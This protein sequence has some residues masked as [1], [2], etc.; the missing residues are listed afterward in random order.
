VRLGVS[1]HHEDMP[2]EPGKRV[3][4]LDRRE[5]ASLPVQWTELE[6]G[7]QLRLL[8]WERGID[9]NHLYWVT[10]HPPHKCWLFVQAGPEPATA[11]PSPSVKGEDVFYR[12]L[13]AE[14]RRSARLACVTH[15][16]Y[17]V[18][19]ELPGPSVDVTPTDL[20]KQLGKL[21]KGHAT[22]RFTSEGGWR[23]EPS[24]N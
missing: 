8:L 12:Q 15:G 18:R 22:V 1:R 19:Y 17:H 7:Q 2:H 24:R 13:V 21:A 14:L 9:P 10:Y 23:A 6:K 11:A 4:R 5:V 20:A 16:A 3:A